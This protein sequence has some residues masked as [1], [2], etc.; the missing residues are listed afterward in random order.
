MSSRRNVL[1]T[2]NAYTNVHAGLWL[3]KFI[4]EQDKKTDQEIS[5]A[6][7]ELVSQVTK[8]AV[9][10]I[11][12]K[13]YQRWE[14]SFQHI[15]DVKIA[16]AKVLGRMAIGLGDESVLETSIK[17][18]HTY[19]IPYIPGSALKGLAAS[20]VRQHLGEQWAK[21]KEAYRTLFGTTKDPETEQAG[22]VTFFDALYIPDTVYN[23]QPLHAD[24]ITVHHPKYYQNEDAAPA[25][26]DQTNPISFLTAT[27]EYLIALAGPKEWV[28]S[29]FDILKLALKELGIGAKTSS[30]YGRMEMIENPLVITTAT[31]PINTASMNNAPNLTDSFITEVTSTPNNKFPIILDV[32]IKRWRLLNNQEQ[33]LVV[34]KTIQEKSDQ[35]NKKYQ[36]RGWYKELSSYIAENKSG[37][38]YD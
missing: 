38:K 2:I 37:E 23:K 35:V 8:I 3:D 30:G 12:K 14:Q 36:E 25:D 32:F 27:G 16:K 15:Q 18:H 5:K 28:E 19:G 17:L 10:D 29:A 4:S 22:Y 31:T 1:T 21:D 6:K 20:Y 11:Y 13:F 24:V 26:W 33:K 34:A 9:P 7:K